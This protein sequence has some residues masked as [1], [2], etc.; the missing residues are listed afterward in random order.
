MS[1]LQIQGLKGYIWIIKSHQH[2]YKTLKYYWVFLKHKIIPIYITKALSEFL[3]LWKWKILVSNKCYISSVTERHC[4]VEEVTGLIFN[5][6]FQEIWKNWTCNSKL[7]VN[8]T[9][10]L[11]LQ[12]ALLESSL[13]L[14]WPWTPSD[15]FSFSLNG[16]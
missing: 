16:F 11:E 7:T 12:K 8:F 13:L 15:F 6:I 1:I 14:L 3:W 5:C 2:R 4:K 9:W 10:C